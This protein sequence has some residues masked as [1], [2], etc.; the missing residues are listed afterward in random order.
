MVI[1]W[2]IVASLHSECSIS[3]EHL[4]YSFKHYISGFLYRAV[5]QIHVS[6]CMILS[7]MN[8]TCFIRLGLRLNS[9][10]QTQQMLLTSWP[11]KKA[12]SYGM[13]HQWIL[14]WWMDTL[15]LRMRNTSVDKYGSNMITLFLG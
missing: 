14:N 11:L 7:L 3:W 4:K 9:Q 1:S 15:G 13:Q 6:S 12:K 10:P 5:S 2:W 8:Q